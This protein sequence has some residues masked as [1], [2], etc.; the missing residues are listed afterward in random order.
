MS[1]GV[2]FMSN[3][4]HNRA[5]PQVVEDAFRAYGNFA[6]IHDFKFKSLFSLD[7][8]TITSTAGVWSNHRQ[9]PALPHSHLITYSTE[10]SYGTAV[11]VNVD[12]APGFNGYEYIVGTDASG[13]PFVNRGS[14]TYMILPTLCPVNANVIVAVREIQNSTEK[15]DVWLSISLWMNDKLMLTYQEWRQSFYPWPN[16]YFGLAS[17]GSSSRTFTNIRIPQMTDFIE[18][19]SLDPAETP[20]GGLS[21]AIQ[22][23]YLKYFV[24]YNGSLYAWRPIT[25]TSIATYTNDQRFQT[26]RRVLD[27]REL[28]THVRQVGAYVQAEYI[29]NDLGPH[30]FAELNNPYLMNIFDCELEALKATERQQEMAD[31]VTFVADCHP[32]V[33]I[34]DHI[35]IPEGDYILTARNGINLTA[36]RASEEIES[37]RYVFAS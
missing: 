2:S 27:R 1:V 8:L 14:N 6:G 28:L 12:Q 23:R 16:L 25:T 32:L 26:L 36:P 21:R 31:I 24:R 13:H 29:R 5:R 30:R 19:N 11:G 4:I 37:R 15:N 22:G 33:E 10:N 18:W 35:T 17:Y 3:F 7:T 34:E 20:S 9:D